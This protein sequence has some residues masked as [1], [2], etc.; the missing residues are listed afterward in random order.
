MGSTSAQ[1]KLVSLRAKNRDTKTDNTIPSKIILTKSPA[2]SGDTLTSNAVVSSAVLNEIGST[3]SMFS[4]VCRTRVGTIPGL[5]SLINGTSNKKQTYSAVQQSSSS[6]SE[7]SSQNPLVN[8]LMSSE[9]VVTLP[10]STTSTGKHI[11]TL[12]VSVM[13]GDD[14]SVNVRDSVKSI[15]YQVTMSNDQIILTLDNTNDN[16]GNWS[17]L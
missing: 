16:T 1:A 4:P 2:K 17:Q 5:A 14:H 6:S 8:R 15:S 3:S 13:D 11:L 12:P 10:L 9:S 7:K